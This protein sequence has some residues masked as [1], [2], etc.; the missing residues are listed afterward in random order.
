M[1]K[2]SNMKQAMYEMFGIGSDVAAETAQ[3]D[4]EKSELNNAEKSLKKSNDKIDAVPAEKP[5]AS[6]L[7][8]GTVFEGT[9]RSVGDVE[10]A[11]TF[12]G[13]ISTEGSALLSSDIQGDVSACSL[14][15]KACKLQGDVKVKGLVVISKDSVVCGDVI[16]D[17][18]KCAGQITGNL[19]IKQN[20]M[21]DNTAKIDGNVTSG[22]ITVMEGAVING[23]I[24]IKP[25]G[26]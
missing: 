2:K 12:K 16:A 6:F 17:R 9:L 11:G 4:K 19:K 8:P 24:E 3:P 22:T 13:D 25:S 23:G 1:D 5:A 26:N 21:L 10:I 14:D 7:A 20:T 15:L 18:L